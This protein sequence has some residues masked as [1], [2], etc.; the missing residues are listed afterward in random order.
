MRPS[1]RAADELK[2]GRNPLDAGGIVGLFASP[3]QRR[4]LDDVQALMSLLEG[5][6]NYVMSALGREHVAGEERMARVLQARRQ[7]GFIQG[8][9]RFAADPAFQ[10]L[11][12]QAE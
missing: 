5:H 7:G 10:C 11:A 12:R 2:R 4:V 9:K 1:G 6:G 3:E 8:R